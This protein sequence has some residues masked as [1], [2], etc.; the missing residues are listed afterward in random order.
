[1]IVSGSVGGLVSGLAAGL[2][3]A[4]QTLLGHQMSIAG[5][6]SLIT[7][8]AVLPFLVALFYGSFSS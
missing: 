7:A 5:T 8:A 4:G 2:L 6:G 3:F 1:M